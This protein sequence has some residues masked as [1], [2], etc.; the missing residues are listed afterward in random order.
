MKNTKLKQ[1]VN[2]NLRREHGM[3]WLVVS[4]PDWQTVS[5]PCKVGLTLRP[6]MLEL[7]GVLQDLP[8]PQADCYDNVGWYDGD[9]PWLPWIP[10]A[11]S[12]TKEFPWN[13]LLSSIAPEYRRNI[14]TYASH[15]LCAYESVRTRYPNTNTIPSPPPMPALG[16]HQEDLS[17]LLHCCLQTL[18]YLHYIGMKFHLK[19]FDHS[20]IPMKKS[21]DLVNSI[22]DNCTSK[23]VA[24]DLGNLGPRNQ[25]PTAAFK[26]EFSQWL[27]GKVPVYILWTEELETSPLAQFMTCPSSPLHVH[28]EN[29]EVNVPRVYLAAENYGSNVGHV[30]AQSESV[31]KKLA[32]RYCYELY[33][34]NYNKVNHQVFFLDY[35]L[36]DA[37]TQDDLVLQSIQKRRLL[38]LS[39]KDSEFGT[40]RYFLSE[41]TMPGDVAVGEGAPPQGIS[42][43]TGIIPSSSPSSLH[44]TPPAPATKVES[45]DPFLATSTAL[46]A[47]SNSLGTELFSRT[48][49]SL[50]SSNPS[51]RSRTDWSTSAKMLVPELIVTEGNP[52]RVTT[53]P[54]STSRF[55][56]AGTTQDLSFFRQPLAK[57]PASDTTAYSIVNPA[58][59]VSRGS[60]DDAESQPPKKRQNTR[61]G[62]DGMERI[63]EGSTQIVGRRD[64]EEV[65]SQTLLALKNKALKI[66]KGWVEGLAQDPKERTPLRVL[67]WLIPDH[68][69]LNGSKITLPITSL[70]WATELVLRNPETSK[71]DIVLF[72]IKH[73]VPLRLA[74]YDGDFDDPALLARHRHNLIDFVPR[75]KP[76]WA[77]DPDMQDMQG[78]LG[79]TPVMK[80]VALPTELEVAGFCL[81]YRKATDSVMFH[82]RLPIVLHYGALPSKIVSKV[83]NERL[84]DSSVKGPSLAWVEYRMG[85]FRDGFWCESYDN[86]AQDPLVPLLLGQFQSCDSRSLWPPYHVFCNSRQWSGVWTSA[87][88]LWFETIWNAIQNG[89]AKMLTPEEWQTEL[90]KTRTTGVPSVDRVR[91]A[92]NMGEKMKKLGVIKDTV[93]D[94]L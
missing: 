1:I 63:M 39:S 80:P 58:A 79:I 65:Q 38:E 78:E 81:S 72:C 69:Y 89:N 90:E 14:S 27:T 9:R 54:A 28:I 45:I 12:K 60:A 55:T 17:R 62:R 8:Y 52:S 77:S 33:L 76:V 74:F 43:G 4:N 91:S 32:S 67:S 82:P 3:L 25:A 59:P 73:G 86:P 23:G 44:T 40:C 61:W 94:Q 92:I 29:R 34:S 36:T 30:I 7:T 75:N 31:A 20:A 68:R 35:P 48:R 49:P 57:A 70:A 11:N 18:A 5:L 21:R 10:V 15:I 64:I 24:L 93:L 19:P 42:T 41:S 16:R 46:A 88:E 2:G 37:K 51:Q 85:T 53:A 13:C 50:F 87:N 22:L 66:A 47:P 26:E 71:T 84:L 6:P 83:G 56:P